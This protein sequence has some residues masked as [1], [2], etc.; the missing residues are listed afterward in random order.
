MD[1]ASKDGRIH[2][3][4]NQI[5]SDDGGT[6]TGRFSMVNPNLQQIPARNQ[7]IGPKIRG[8]FLPEEGQS[9]LA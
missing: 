6:V 9:G 5:R 3:H 8:L 4:I 2:S 7:N 1:F